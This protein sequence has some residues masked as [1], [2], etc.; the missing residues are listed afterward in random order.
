MPSVFYCGQT[1]STHFTTCCQVAI[2]A[3]ESKCPRCGAEITPRSERSR[4]DVAMRKLYGSKAVDEMRRKWA[5]KERR[6]SRIG[7]S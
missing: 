2:T 1:N 7:R 5:E 4:H 6:E 3:S